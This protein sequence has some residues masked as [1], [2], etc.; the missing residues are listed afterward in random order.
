MLADADCGFCMRTADRVPRLGV[1]VDV[2]TIQQS[3]LAALGVDPDRA[4]AEM[5]YVHPDGRVDYG[6]RAWAA[7]LAT[8]P[9][10]WRLVGRAMTSR[11]VD[12]LSARVY[13]WVSRNREMLPGGTP[14]CSLDGR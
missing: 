10:P 14:A 7:V 2:A 8:G 6:H 1:R 13:G 3:D 11:P 4:V 12:P 5:P 9:L